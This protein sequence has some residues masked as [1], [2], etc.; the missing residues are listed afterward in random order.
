[1]VAKKTSTK[2]N[3]PMELRRPTIIYAQKQEE[4]N[5]RTEIIFPNS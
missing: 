2:N 5:L 4:Q 1:M 3:K